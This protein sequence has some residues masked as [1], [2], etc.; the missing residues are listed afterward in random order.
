M[1]LQNKKGQGL[2]TSTIILLILGLIILVV[3]IWGFVTGWSAMNNLI[4]PSNVDQVIQDCYAACSVN[5]AYSYC[6]A[7]RVLRANE[8]KINTKSTCAVFSHEPSFLKY[9]IA[10]CPTIDCNLQCADVVIDGKKGSVAL[11]SG[12]YDLSSLAKEGSCFIN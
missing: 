1:A 3:L 8:Y 7:E 6:S 12:K 10:D 9:N 4:N 2:S 5:S 11:T